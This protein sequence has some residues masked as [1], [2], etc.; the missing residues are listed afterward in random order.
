MRVRQYTPDR[1]SSECS[2][3]FELI[4]SVEMRRQDS[5]GIVADIANLV[6]RRKGHITSIDLHIEKGVSSTNCPP[7]PPADLPSSWLGE[8]RYDRSISWF[9]SRTVFSYDPAV[10]PDSELEKDFKKLGVNWKARV[11]KV[12]VRAH[13]KRKMGRD[14]NLK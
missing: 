4:I 9:N 12:R 1:K 2:L 5:G 13:K 7:T 8:E 11:N 6:D 3:L 10:W 14:H